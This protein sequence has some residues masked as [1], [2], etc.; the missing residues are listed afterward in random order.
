MSAKQDVIG[1]LESE[2]DAFRGQIAT[3]PES[4][5]SETWLGDWNL[6]QLLAHMAG[7][8]NEMSGAFDRVG[9]GERPV[10][11]GVDYSDS[12]KWNE[13]FAAAAKHGKAA[14]QDWD[15]AFAKYSGAAKSLADDLFG[16]DPER[17]RPRIGDR[18]LDASGIS[19]F[20]EHRPQL[21]EWLKKR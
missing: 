19:H 2:Y 6:D 5:F 9:R 21:E 1:R 11:E 12:D 7:W 15:D 3:L 14:L 17:G 18:L 16:V 20:G 13:G 4:A 8:W 10:P